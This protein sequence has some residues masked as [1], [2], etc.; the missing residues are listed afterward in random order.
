MQGE[1][2]ERPGEHRAQVPGQVV[3][4]AIEQV[5]QMQPGLGLALDGKAPLEE[6]RVGVFTAPREIDEI[7]QGPAD[8]HVRRATSAPEAACDD[9]ESQRERHVIDGQ[10][11]TLAGEFLEP[12]RKQL[13][14]QQLVDG[15][16]EHARLQWRGRAAKQAPSHRNRISHGSLP[17]MT[18]V[19]ICHVQ[20]QHRLIS[21]K[22]RHQGGTRS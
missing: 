2:R 22:V 17:G 21:V 6:Q 5:F 3:F 7:L 11:E 1:T 9:L 20:R 13:A 4:P 18:G 14:A 15:E 10:A 12:A 16:R 8:R 19:H